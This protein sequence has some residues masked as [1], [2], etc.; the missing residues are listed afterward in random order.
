MTLA[1]PT[2]AFPITEISAFLENMPFPVVYMSQ[3]LDILYYNESFAAFISKGAIHNGPLYIHDFMPEFQPNGLHSGKSLHKYMQERSPSFQTQWVLTGLNGEALMTKLTLAPA[4]A[5]PDSNFF[6]YIHHE[7]AC[8]HCLKEA[9][10]TLEF[11]NNTLNTMP[12]TMHIWSRDLQLIDCSNE[13]INMFGAPSK[14]EYKK[15]V[16]NYSPAYQVDGFSNELLPEYLEKA[17]ADGS[18]KFQWIHQ[19]HTGKTFPTEETFCRVSFQ[20][21]DFILGYTQ[22]IS[23]VT[24]SIKNIVHMEERTRAILDATPM[25]ILLWDKNFKLKDTNLEAL[26][27]YN[28]EDKYDFLQEFQDTLP[29]LQPDGTDSTICIQ[30]ALKAAFETGYYHMPKYFCRDKDGAELPVEVTIIRIVIRDETMVIAYLRDLREILQVLQTM[31][32]HEERIQ[33]ILDAAPMAINLW[34]SSLTLRDTNLECLRLFGFESKQDF[35]DNF[36][37]IV[38]KSYAHGVPIRERIQQNIAQALE[39][40]YL[41]YESSLCH[42][43]GEKIPLEVS[44][45]R[46]TLSNETMIIAYLRD[47]RE[48]KNFIKKITESEARTQA[49]L[50]LSPLGINVW[51]SNRNLVDCNKAIVRLFGFSSREEY[52]EHRYAVMPETQEDGTSSHQLALHK[53]DEA[54]ALGQ[55]HVEVI[56]KDLQG[57]TIPLDVVIKRTTLGEQEVVIAY[58]QDLRELKAMLAEIHAVEQDLRSA[59]DVAVQSARAKSEFLANMSHEIRTPLNGVLGL[60]HLLDKTS[61]EQIQQSYVDKTIFSAENLL[62]IIND[63]LDFSKIDAGKLEMEIIPFAL[64]EVASELKVLFEPQ[65]NTKNLTL[66]FKYDACTKHML[67]GDPLR[68]KQVFFNLIGNAIKFTESGGII[69]QMTGHEESPGKVHC[70]FSVQDSGIGMNEE[71][72][73]R[74][75]SAFMQADTSVT[76]KYGGT[77]LGLVIAQRIARLMHGDLWVESS[78]GQGSTFFFSAIFDIAHAEDVTCVIMEQNIEKGKPYVAIPSLED[79]MTAPCDN[80]EQDSSCTK[81]CEESTT[82]EQTSFH[83]LLVEDNEINQLIAEELLKNGGHTVDIA[84]NGQ[85]ALDL[86]ENNNY[87]IVL[88]DIQ[89]PV[90]DGLSTVR[91]IRADERLAHMPVIAMSAHAMTGDREISLHHG[92]NEHITKPISPQILYETVNT[93]A[94][95][96]DKK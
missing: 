59:R 89:M 91:K 95:R 37:N 26:R 4:N 70:L 47:L 86:L 93:W 57:N 27:I 68:I 92:M 23:A 75:F 6:L 63:I 12:L 18:Y 71:Q 51:D 45:I 24:D 2:Q 74:L 43:N 15:N 53:I 19:D 50:D 29:A 48:T 54:F 5:Q 77:G 78:E 62:R 64:D 40:G 32:L 66:T 81:P 41:H 35:K 58:M 17:F 83:I 94:L 25:A 69:I 11:I 72:C 38:P 87:H 20:G 46:I 9:S 31:K 14:E 80:L 1:S 73:S 28:Y 52:I 42:S 21:E 56:G 79:A 33:A 36:F 49:I 65:A 85:E 34:D 13:V 67:L 96:P 88:M 55:S 90:L 60:L 39:E 10:K 8:Q 61:L 3:K 82:Q 30:N 22:D 16:M 44:L 84:N 76:R 7:H